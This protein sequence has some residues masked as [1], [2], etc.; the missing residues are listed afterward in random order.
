MTQED[1]IQYIT[2]Y[3]AYTPLNMDKET[4]ARKK[5]ESFKWKLQN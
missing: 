4:G 2:T 5:L 3:A 1:A